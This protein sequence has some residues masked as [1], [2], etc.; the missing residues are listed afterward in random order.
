V[1][2]DPHAVHVD[3]VRL[4]AAESR[5]RRDGHPGCLARHEDHRHV[6]VAVAGTRATH[7]QDVTR[8]VGVRAPHLRAVEH[9]LSILAA[10]ARL[11]RR[12][13][14]ACLRLGHRDRQ[15]PALHDVAEVLALLLLRSEAVQ[16]A[17]DD[18]RHAV[19][20]DRDLTAREL[21]EEERGIQER[22]AR[23]AVLLRDL[24]PV[25]PQLAHARGHLV[26]VAVVLG[27]VEL[28]ARG[29]VADGRDERLL[30][31]AQPHASTGSRGLKRFS[32]R[33]AITILWTSSGP[34]AIRS[35]RPW[36]HAAASG[37]SSDIPSAPCTCIARSSTRWCIWAAMTLIIEMSCRAARLPS[38]SIVQASCR[39]ISRAWSISIRDVAMKSWTNCFSASGPPNA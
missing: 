26:R 35:Q 20:G 16:R 4:L 13:V 9:P 34:S 23:A 32:S 27:P 36:R 19:G 8:L 5:N 12:H 14:R 25:P 30:L 3:L 39:T 38:V 17:H 22:A 2:R 10:G 15:R 21:L 31:L 28:L 29:E 24:E 6:L 11:Q 7:D 1:L 33:S 37:V 18:Q